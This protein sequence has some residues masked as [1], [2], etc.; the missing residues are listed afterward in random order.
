MPFA[1]A[2]STAP[3]TGRALDDV[4]GE[5]GGR[6]SPIELACVFFSPHH[7]DAAAAIAKTIHDR[8]RPKALIGCIGEAIV[9]TGQE[10]EKQ[11]AL[12]LWLAD[13]AG[14]VAAEPFHLAPRQTS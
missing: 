13:W 4:C 2:L 12:S 6:L 9:G 5:V 7:A 10:I 3:A 8:L 11:P 14:R 1:A